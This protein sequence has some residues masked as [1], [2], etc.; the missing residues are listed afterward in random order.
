[1]KKISLAVQNL[2]CSGC[3]TSIA[4]AL[5][6]VKGIHDFEIEVEQSNISFNYEN[7]EALQNVILKLSGMGYPMEGNENPLAKKAKS[8]LSCVTGRIAETPE[9]VKA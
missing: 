7:E 1:M 3:G 5:D 2:K 9:N 6:K 4:K 8:Y